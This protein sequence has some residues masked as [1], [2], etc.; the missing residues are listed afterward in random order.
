MHGSHAALLPFAHLVARQAPCV[1]YEIC[2]AQR[3]KILFE[4]ISHPQW[5]KHSRNQITFAAVGAD[6]LIRVAGPGVQRFHD[7]VARRGVCERARR[8]R[9][10]RVRPEV[11]RIEADFEGRRGRLTSKKSHD[12]SGGDGKLG[13][14]LRPGP[15]SL[16]VP[17]SSRH[18]L[19]KF[20]VQ[21][22]DT[23]RFNQAL[24]GIWPLLRR[25]Q[26]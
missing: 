4:P 10:A 1:R 16:I 15:D 18:V 20:S 6:V 26:F 2:N 5:S 9:V 17:D 24:T 7:R 13:P 12:L 19:H 22:G 25:S 11:N 21:P 3:I 23:T 14:G 8:E